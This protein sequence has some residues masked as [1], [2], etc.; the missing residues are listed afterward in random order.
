MEHIQRRGD[1]P[2]DEIQEY[3]MSS[4]GERAVKPISTQAYI[5]QQAGYSIGSIFPEEQSLQRGLAP[6]GDIRTG[7]A[8]IVHLHLC[9]HHLIC[10]L[11]FLLGR[12][13]PF[14]EKGLY[15]FET[16][17]TILIPAPMS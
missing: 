7:C 8:E 15:Q 9:Q 2:R 13:A 12:N 3:V 5:A 16:S 11:D 10:L 17:E 14:N 4:S 6:H 1:R